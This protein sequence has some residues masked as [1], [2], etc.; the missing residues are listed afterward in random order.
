MMLRKCLC[1]HCRRQFHRI[2][3]QNQFEMTEMCLTVANNVLNCAKSIDQIEPKQ[4]QKNCRKIY[5]IREML[6]KGKHIENCKNFCGTDQ[7]VT[8]AVLNLPFAFFFHSVDCLQNEW[9]VICVLLI[10]LISLFIDWCGSVDGRKDL[11]SIN[12]GST[13]VCDLDQLI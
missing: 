8:K 7:I 4:Q 6:G 1:V 5:K 10:S 3:V 12:I 2:F 9:N 13:I 11:Q